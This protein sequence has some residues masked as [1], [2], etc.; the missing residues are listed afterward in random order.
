VPS[1]A[2]RRERIA[3]LGEV[4]NEEDVTFP[5]A[6]RR[7]ITQPYDLSVQTLIEQ[8]NNGLLILPEIQRQY[9]WDDGK[10]S[11]LIES[12]LLNIPIP[13]VYFAETT[14]A[15]YEVIDGHQRIRSMVRYV[16]NQ[17]ALTGLA[18]L[19]EYKGS[20]FH[21]LP[22][23]EQRFLKSR[24]LRA[25]VISVES[26]PSMKFEIFE[27]LNSGAVTLNAQEL[28]NSL[29]R[30]P[31]NRLIREL[32]KNDDL[33]TIV[34]TRTPRPRMVDEELVLRF[35]ALHDELVTYRPSLKRF[36][37][38][39][40]N[41]HRNDDAAHLDG[42][43]DMFERAIRIVHALIG[44]GAFR[45]TDA[46]GDPTEPAVNRALYDAQM[47]AASWTTDDELATY[48]EAVLS[49]LTALYDSPDFR[50]SIQRATGDRARTLR[51]VRETV[52]AFRAAGLA[53]EVP[54]DLMQ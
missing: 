3:D 38:N 13:V 1:D 32:A 29:Y 5:P 48:R 30:G 54:F 14:D 46:A 31:F 25:I 24:T 18:M 16:D 53:V 51:R 33:R 35:F 49:Q 17:F 8:W 42:L 45:M 26:H 11:R 10:A 34:G 7:I 47:L 27:R 21:Q 22:E 43:R 23:R 15:K 9:V 2:V 12:L 36:L 52:A 4:D 20:R 28:R 44:D 6:E 41:K 50:D 40:M 39:Y 37:N 19:P